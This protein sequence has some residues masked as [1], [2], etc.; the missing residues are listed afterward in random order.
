MEEQI[1]RPTREEIILNGKISY[2]ESNQAWTT[3][4][5]KKELANEFK[6]LKEKTNK[7]RY[8]AIFYQNYNSLEKFLRKMN[9]ESRP[10]PI[11][12]WFVKEKN[13]V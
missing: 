7:F 11:L 8:R 4:R 2:N 12:L 6:S 10:L 13:I 3:I 1:L 9:K 5:F